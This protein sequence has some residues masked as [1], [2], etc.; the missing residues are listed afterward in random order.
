VDG[1]RVPV[2]QVTIPETMI[3]LNYLEKRQLVLLWQQLVPQALLSVDKTRNKRTYQF[4]LSGLSRLHHDS[5]ACSHHLS[6]ARVD[7]YPMFLMFLEMISTLPL[8]LEIGLLLERP[9]L[10]WQLPPI[11]PTQSLSHRELKVVFILHIVAEPT[12]LR[13]RLWMLLERPNSVT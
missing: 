4:Y 13:S 7:L 5:H 8:Q 12:A 9:L 10:S 1:R 11:R 2:I 6:E 3:R